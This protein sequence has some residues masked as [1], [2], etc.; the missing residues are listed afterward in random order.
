MRMNRANKP[1][2]TSFT[3][4]LVLSGTF[5]NLSFFADFG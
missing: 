2:G 5:A 1:F 3:S 4:F